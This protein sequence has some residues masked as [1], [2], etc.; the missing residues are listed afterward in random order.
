M[1]VQGGWSWRTFFSYCGPGF[2]VAIAYLDPGNLEAN[3][4]VSPVSAA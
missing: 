4:Q 3:L 2:L 1:A